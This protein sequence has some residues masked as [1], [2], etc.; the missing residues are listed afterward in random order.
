MSA[1]GT[2]NGDG[3]AVIALKYPAELV[4]LSKS[5]RR[6]DGREHVSL[7]LV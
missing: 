6:R 2:S 3:R 1:Y 4:S 5:V 7:L